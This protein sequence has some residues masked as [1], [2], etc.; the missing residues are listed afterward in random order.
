MF[1]DA[2]ALCGIGTVYDDMTT[3]GNLN[4]GRY[5]S[6]ARVDTNCWSTGHSVAAHE[7]THTLGGVQARAPHATKNGHC[8]DESDLMC[9]DDSSGKVMRTVCAQAQEQLLDCH[10]D[11]YFSTAPVAGSYLA[12]SWNTA[13]SSFLDVLPP[14]PD[15]T[16]RSSASAAQTGDPVT[17]TATST[18]AV[19][20]RW[21]ASSNACSLTPSAGRACCSARR[22]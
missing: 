5:A 15:V 21:T 13:G 6:Y 7:L 11:D 10:H 19:S 17:F 14:T 22:S 18:K 4:D 20:W 3:S 1:A 8:Y 9:Y 2:N 16:V 12:K